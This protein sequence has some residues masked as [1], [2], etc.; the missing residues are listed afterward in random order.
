MIQIHEVTYS[1][2]LAKEVAP[3]L[4][5]HWREIAH[6][7][8]AVPLAVD[9]GVYERASM[10][11]RLLILTARDEGKL[12]AYCV[13]FIT[14]S[15]H[16]TS[17]LYALNDVLYVVPEYRNTRTGLALIRESEKRLRER[18]CQRIS[19]HVKE[20]NADGSL[21]PLGTIL[22]RLGYAVEELHLGKLL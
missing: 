5:R 1:E 8:T 16:Y 13:F 3:L 12:I 14:R 22:S 17:T 19:W 6:Y 11:K 9:F 18:G 15:P 4:E 2:T 20:K 10:Q 21:N 7:Q